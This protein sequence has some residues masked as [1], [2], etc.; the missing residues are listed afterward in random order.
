MSL[1]DLKILFCTVDSPAHLHVAHI[2]VEIEQ[3]PGA[4][5]QSHYFIELRPLGRIQIEHV[6]DQLSEFWA[7]PVRDR[8]KS[9]T[10]DF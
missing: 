5:G 2:C 10:H 7:V 8:S 6:E 4:N 3:W 1:E 9:S